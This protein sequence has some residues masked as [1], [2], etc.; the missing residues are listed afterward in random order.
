MAVNLNLLPQELSGNTPLGKAQAGIK[1]ATYILIP[2]FLIF[3]A[4]LLIF[5]AVLS[6]QIAGATDKLE[7]LKAEIK[8]KETTE[9][10]LVLVRDRISK[11]KLT[12]NSP[13]ATKRIANM[14]ALLAIIPPDS[15]IGE[16]S[17]D[18]GKTEISVIF[19]STAGMTLFF[20]NLA[21]IT[22]YKAIDMTSFG[23]SP[24]NGYLISLRLI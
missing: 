14:G 11:V 6:Y 8:D 19:K 7:G 5:Y 4:G 18:S 3:A 21:K 2:L 13:A 17:L 12:K 20:E 9:Q 1:K 22:G 10:K 16:L 15:T 24:T 23:F